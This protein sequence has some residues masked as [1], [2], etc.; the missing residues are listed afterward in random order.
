MYICIYIYIYIFI[1]CIHIIYI[2]RTYHSTHYTHI[3]SYLNYTKETIV[4]PYH[5]PI[6]IIIVVLQK[7]LLDIFSCSFH[8]LW[9]FKRK[10]TTKKCCFF[11]SH[12]LTTSYFVLAICCFRI[13]QLFFCHIETTHDL[14]NVSFDVRMFVYRLKN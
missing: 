6:H 12:D 13:P 9:T 3:L 4:R 5:F 11:S 7:A 10:N 8:N 14:V 2:T 1:P